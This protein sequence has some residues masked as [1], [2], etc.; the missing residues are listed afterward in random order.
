MG[1]TFAR[2][3]LFFVAAPGIAALIWFDPT[4]HLFIINTIVCIVAVGAA[5]EC[6]NLYK[7]DVKD[8]AVVFWSMVIGSLPCFLALLTVALAIPL[9]YYWIILITVLLISMVVQ[10]L[11]TSGVREDNFLMRMSPAFLLMFY[12]GVFLSHFILLA[13]LELGREVVLT[14]F[15]CVI[16]NDSMAYLFGKLFGKN[17]PNPFPLSPKKTLVGLIAGLLASIGA[18]AVSW[19]LVPQLYPL[20]LWSALV[21]GLVTGLFAVAGDLIESGLKRSAGVKDSGTMIPGRGGIMDSLDSA[22]FAAPLFFLAFYV[23]QTVVKNIS[24][25][26]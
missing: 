25:P 10:L 16:L 20:G 11:R 21:I 23:M 2:F 18:L 22:T 1:N 19:A 3:A 15:F 6:A 26:F 13:G 17:S 12:P 7:L 14:F 8:R 24:S 9:V 4:P 5:L